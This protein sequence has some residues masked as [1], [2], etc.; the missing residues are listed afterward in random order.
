M[1]TP[2]HSKLINKAAREVLK[3]IGLVRKGQSRLWLDDNAWWL[4]MVE[5]QPSSWSKG[6][7]LNVGISWLWYPKDYMSFDIGYRENSFIEFKDEDTFSR[8]TI[9]LAEKAKECVFSLRQSMSSPELAKAFVLENTKGG[10]RNIWGSLNKGLACLHALDF[11]GARVHLENVIQCSD[12]RDW[13]ISV[14]DF[15]QSILSLQPKEQIKATQ[16]AIIQS[17]KLKKLPEMN[18]TFGA[19]A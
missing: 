19:S 9:A 8:D 16:D 1:A 14:K 18:V 5:F 12:E 4:I 7:Y 10:E 15:T 3:P 17:R 11:Q 13:A 2:V 6:T